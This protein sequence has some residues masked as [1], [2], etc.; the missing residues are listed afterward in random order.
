M[1]ITVRLHTR[2]RHSDGLAD[3]EVLVPQPGSTRGRYRRERLHLEL[4][5][6]HQHFGPPKAS[7]PL[8]VAL[9]F[10]YLASLIYLIDR[11]VPREWAADAWTREIKV[12]IPISNANSWSTVA[13]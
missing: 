3:V 5:P 1:T 7:Q 11:A 4:T 12:E 8:P 9:E 10:L 2:A 13:N 6:F